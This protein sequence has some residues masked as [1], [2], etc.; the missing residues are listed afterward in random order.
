MRAAGTA[1]SYNTGALLGG[2]LHP[3]IDSR[4]FQ[5]A[6]GHLPWAVA[7]CLTGVC[8]VSLMCLLRLPAR[9]DRALRPDRT[10]LPDRAIL[11][12]TERRAVV[13]D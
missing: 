7:A 9:P 10:D 1:I 2:A 6:G 11:P 4:L 13:K 3:L 5:S 8:A 12:D